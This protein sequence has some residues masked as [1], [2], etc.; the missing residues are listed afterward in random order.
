MDAPTS[1]SGAAGRDDEPR[2]VGAKVE[3]RLRRVDGFQQRHRALAIPIGVIKKFG[4]DQAGNLAALVAYYTFFSLFPLL[5]LLTTIVGFVLHDDPAAQQAVVDSVLDR[6]PGFGDQLAGNI[7]EFQ[8]SSLAV[9]VGAIGA[10]W[11]GL[12]ALGAMQNAMNTIWA[13][14]FDKRPPFLIERVR[15]LV[16]LLVLGSG[17]IATT[18]ITNVAS[19]LSDLP[20]LAR[21]LVVVA[22]L[23]LNI[24]LFLL[25][26]KVLTRHGID[27]RTLLPGAVVAGVVFL[28]LQSVGGW[29]IDRTLGRA[30]PLYGTFAVVLGLLTWLYIQAQLTMVAA[31]LNVVLA[32][33]LYPRSLIG[34]DLADL[35]GA[36]ERAL[37]SYAAI[38]RRHPNQQVSVT[39]E[40]P[41]PDEEANGHEPPVEE[42]DDGGTAAEDVGRR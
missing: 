34:T 28:V 32:R 26:F 30:T 35:T 8:G 23:A 2:G 40:A 18:V 36:D 7:G 42:T 37:T 6:F 33:R 21:W 12:G 25:A 1:D 9:V 15:S 11:G 20:T 17:A 4:D 38:Q 41:A 3:H 19:S 39:F 27:W 22:T 24:G 29:Y 5:L 10:L 31:E 14:P 16:M 13:V